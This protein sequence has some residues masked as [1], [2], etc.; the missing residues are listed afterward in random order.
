MVN[1][2]NKGV[3]HLD[4]FCSDILEVMKKHNVKE[5]KTETGNFR[6][7]INLEGGLTLYNSIIF[8]DVS[9]SEHSKL[10]LRP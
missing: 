10:V 5:I 7:F 1:I 9:I 4:V 2:Y 6:M 3:L 8:T